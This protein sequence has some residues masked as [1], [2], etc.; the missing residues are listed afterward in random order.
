MV[1]CGRRA[2]AELLPL[3]LV[4]AEISDAVPET[5]MK[6]APA[7]VSLIRIDGGAI[8]SI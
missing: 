3:A 4:D 7:P 2:S 1:G 6:S 5:A 8:R